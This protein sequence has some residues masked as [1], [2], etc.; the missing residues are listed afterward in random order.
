[1]RLGDGEWLA[2]KL[3]GFDLNKEIHPSGFDYHKG[4]WSEGYEQAECS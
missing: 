1:V 2:V 3:L 4:G